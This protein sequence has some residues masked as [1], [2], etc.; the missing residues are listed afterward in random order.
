MPI[1]H[2]LNNFYVSEQISVQDLVDFQQQG[3]KLIICNRPDN[4]VAEQPSFD[5]IKNEASKL[6]IECVYL[7]MKD[8]N[9]SE[10][11]IQDFQ[12]LINQ[13]KGSVLGYCRTG[14]RSSILWSAAMLD[15]LP[16]NQV[17]DATN[18]AGYNLSE[19]IKSMYRNM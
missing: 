10:Q 17:I 4:E 1:K 11:L 18:Q 15:E 7:P 16:I 3:I 8:Q 5:S 2:L 12:Q 6:G 9:V 14:T 13:P 19:L